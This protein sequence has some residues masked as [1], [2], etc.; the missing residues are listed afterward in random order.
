MPPLPAEYKYP[1]VVDKID[2]FL[3]P[4]VFLFLCEAPRRSSLAIVD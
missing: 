1:T 3:L 4:I 2:I